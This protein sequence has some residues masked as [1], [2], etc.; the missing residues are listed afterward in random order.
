MIILTPREAIDIQTDALSFFQKMT[1]K[2]KIKIF[3]EN[4]MDEILALNDQLDRDAK[5]IER[6]EASPEDEKLR[7]YSLS[8][9]NGSKLT[10]IFLNTAVL[11]N[12]QKMDICLVL[13]THCQFNKKQSAKVKHILEKYYNL[14]NRIYDI[15]MLKGIFDKIYTSNM[16]REIT[17][18]EEFLNK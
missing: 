8:S 16:S 1:I 2:K 18:L 7:K 3:I 15:A 14:R 10:E 9:L 17:Y 4:Y 12:C 6:L 11:K 13:N 5:V